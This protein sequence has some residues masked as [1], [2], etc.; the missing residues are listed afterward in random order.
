MMI[1]I[2]LPNGACR[3][4][5]DG[6]TPAKVAAAIATSLSKAALAA[7]VNGEL[8]GLDRPFEGDATL[9]IVTA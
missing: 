1:K 2:T 5:P 7:R 3:K 8:L 9:S 6:T 4:V